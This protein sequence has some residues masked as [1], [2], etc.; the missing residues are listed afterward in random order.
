MLIDGTLLGSWRHH[1]IIPWD[2][3]LDI[4]I[5]IEDKERFVELVSKMNETLI[6]F[7]I[8]SNK[9]KK[10]E[11]YK[12]YLKNTPSAG[13]YSWNFP[14][15]DIYLY[16]HNET[17][18][19]QMKDP[20]TLVESKYVF[21]LVMRPLGELWLPTPRR[22]D[23]L[24]SFDPYDECKSHYWDHKNE[25]GKETVTVKCADLKDIYP[26]VERTNQ[27]NSDEILKLNNTIIHTIIF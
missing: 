8:L 26:F 23:K 17:H 22:P 24:F 13:P 12:I 7:H 6:K 11:Y 4:M 5:P 1:D 25:T 10:R 9:K 21:P 16:E 27:S 18:I 15:L 19:W 3:D 20:D 2:D 14:F